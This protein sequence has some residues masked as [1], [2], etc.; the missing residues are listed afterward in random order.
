MKR[1]LAA[2]A[3]A[4][5]PA[6]ARPSAAASA[7]SCTSPSSRCSSGI[8][9]SPASEQLMR[10]TEQ[11]VAHVAE[12]VHGSTRVPGAAR[13]RSTS[14]PPWPRA[15][16]ARRLR[17]LRG[18]S[19]L[20]E[21]AAPTKSAFYRDAGRAGR[22]RAGPRQ[23]RVPDATTPRAWPRS[24][25]CSPDDPRVG[26]ALRGLRGRASSCATASA[27]SPIPP[28]SAR[29]FEARSAR[30]R[31]SSA[32]VYPIDERFLDAL[33]D[34]MP[35]SGGNALGVDRLLMLLLGK[36]DIADVLAFSAERVSVGRAG[37]LAAA[38]VAGQREPDLA[39]RARAVEAE[40]DRLS[41]R[42]GRARRT[43]GSRPRR[44][45]RR[46][47]RAPRRARHDTDRGH[48]PPCRTRPRSSSAARC[49]RC[50]RPS[51]RSDRWSRDSQLPK[52]NC[53]R[54]LSCAGAAVSRI[55]GSKTTVVRLPTTSISAG[56]SARLSMT[57]TPA[58][59]EPVEHGLVATRLAAGEAHLA[60][61]AV[62]LLDEV[63]AVELRAH[64]DH[65]ERLAVA[66]IAELVRHDQHTQYRVRPRLR[67]RLRRPRATAPRQ[68]MPRPVRVRIVR[69]LRNA[70]GAGTAR[71]APC[72]SI[73]GKVGLQKSGRCGG[74]S[75]RPPSPRATA[76]RAGRRRARRRSSP[77]SAAA[78]STAARA[79]R[80]ARASGAAR[81]R[82]RARACALVGER[83]QHVAELA[84]GVRLVA[85][86]A[87]A[88]S[89]SRSSSS[90]LSRAPCPSG[91]SK[92][93]R[94]A[95]SPMRSARRSAGSAS[96][97]PSSAPRPRFS[98]ALIASQLASTSAVP[99]T[100]ASSPNTCGWRRTSL[101]QIAATTSSGPNQ[102]LRARQLG[103]EDDLQQQIAEL[104]AQVVG[105]AAID[106][107]DHLVRLFD[108]VGTQRLQRLLAVPRASVRREQALHDL[109]EPW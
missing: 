84:F 51:R 46:S 26:R 58:L 3:V 36:R 10:D 81:P 93:T 95:F 11:L 37:A 32:A 89:S 94:A 39:A 106:R 14:T 83:E 21:R 2:G 31:A 68:R 42:A 79:A 18:S 92:P 17:A 71:G 38:D 57:A 66:R 22:A 35:P 62:A 104:L 15:D 48:R 86:R 101:S 107:V 45:R 47:T 52:P 64:G 78:R 43:A 25:A 40:G 41:D 85:R 87:R 88:S 29:R 28:S 96:G 44:V 6:R 72:E 97:T 19:A 30:A 74:V 4:H 27:S 70:P 16:R 67:S 100:R 56:P 7:A 82:G 12:R 49:R 54:S 77:R 80:S 33:D 61:V 23:A 1:L 108:H 69:L 13:A 24:R 55:A 105:R 73:W 98:S 109:D 103:L 65:A 76:R 102:P 5:L 8:A 63:A 75:V 53:Q 20:D 34:G 99:L 59:V 91:Q 9:P 50:A 60:V 90:T